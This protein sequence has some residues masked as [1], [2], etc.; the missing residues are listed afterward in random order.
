MQFYTGMCEFSH[1]DTKT[2]YKVTCC[3]N[4]YKQENNI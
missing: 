3:Y 2:S 4:G 1:K